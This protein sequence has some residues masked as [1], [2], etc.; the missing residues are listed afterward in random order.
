MLE[1]KDLPQPIRDRRPESARAQPGHVRRWLGRV[2]LL[3]VRYEAHAP[4]AL[5]PGRV[6][7]VLETD[8]LLD[9][10]VLEDLCLRE[11]WPLPDDSR[12]ADFSACARFAA[13]CC[14][15]SCPATCR[16]RARGR[17]R[18]GTRRRAGVVRPDSDLLGRA[19]QR[20]SS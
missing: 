12:A 7:Y 2:A 14:G 17:A 11:R 15:G 16:A 10:L 5:P 13:G 8:R 4:A 9:R 18:H 3:P 20:D 19:P 6:C 1:S